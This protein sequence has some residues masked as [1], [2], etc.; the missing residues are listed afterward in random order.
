MTGFEIVVIAGPTA[1]GKS[2]LA[3][4]LAKKHDAA[5]LSADA[6]QVYRGMD[7]GTATPTQHEQAEVVHY[8]INICEPD[9]S[10]NAADFVTLAE[11]TLKANPRLII[12]GGTSLYLRS[13]MRGLVET[14]AIRP[15]LREELEQTPDLYAQLEQHDPVL[16]ARLHPNDRVRIIR[17]LEVALSGN[18]LLSTLHAEHA[19]QPD[20]YQVQGLWVDRDDLYQR[21]DTRVLQMVDAGYVQEVESLLDKGLDRRLK[22]LQSLGYRHLCDHLLEGLPLEEA[23]RRTQRDTRHFSRKQ[24]N[25]MKQLGFPKLDDETLLAFECRVGEIFSKN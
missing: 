21:I 19:K 13:L 20:R 7:I 24:R 4:R 22:P 11:A 14:P 15:G 10:F 6:M 12:V 23:I 2:A 9:A 8:G 18:T 3:M 16:A 17:G 5:I 1:A 25:W